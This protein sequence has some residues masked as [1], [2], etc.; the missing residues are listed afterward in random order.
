MLS[1]N[2]GEIPEASRRSLEDLLGRRLQ[3]NQRVFIMVFDPTKVPSD[4]QRAGAAAGLRE[5]IGE[6]ERHAAAA[7]VSDAEI[8]AA[9]EEAM[10]DVRRRPPN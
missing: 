9:V 1:R 3:E 2:V 5:I 4:E 6:A 8:D 10:S 7:G